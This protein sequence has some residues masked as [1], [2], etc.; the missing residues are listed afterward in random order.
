MKIDK[1]ELFKRD[2][3]LID[4]NRMI[5]NRKEVS[6]DGSSK[7]YWMRKTRLPDMIA[8]KEAEQLEKL[9]SIAKANYQK[10]LVIN[11]FISFKTSFNTLTIRNGLNSNY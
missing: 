7:N 4:A 3:G 1:P 11:K 6:E 2:I 9:L 5:G 8:R 10:S